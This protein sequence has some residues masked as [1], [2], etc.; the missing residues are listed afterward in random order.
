M[1]NKIPSDGITEGNVLVQFEDQITWVTLNRPEKRNC[2]NPALN[3]DM[4][5]ILDA[6]EVDDR[7]QVLVL[8]GAGESFSSGMD[9]KEF[10]RET[11]G[12]PYNQMM[13]VRRAA[14]DWQWRQL[15]NFPKP[16]IAMVNGWCFGGAFTPLISCDLAIAAEDATFGLSEINWGIIPAGLVTRAVVECMN[17]RNAMYYTLTGLPFDG[18]KAA[19]IGLVNEAVPK[20]ML[21][22]RTIEVAKILLGKNPHALRACKQVVRGVQGLPFDLSFDYLGA[23]IAQMQFFDDEKGRSQGMSQFLDEKS[24]RPGLQSMSRKKKSR[25]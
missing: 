19:E 8:T 1:V 17:V 24:Y 14:A 12:L 25:R 21:R 13:R 11:D 6:L 22:K 23:K 4:V 9:L 5:R 10:F 16:T 18:K 20:A 2:M 7:C 3:D 15:M